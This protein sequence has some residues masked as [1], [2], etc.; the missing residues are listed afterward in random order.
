MKN[1]QQIVEGISIAGQPTADELKNLAG[2]GYR[3]VINLR[4]EG[5]EGAGAD[6]ER[7]VEGAGVNYSSIPIS[8]QTIDDNAVTR[9]IQALDSEDGRP[10]VA[11]CGSGGRAGIMVLLHEA[12]KHAWSVDQALA[13][14]AKLGIAP[15]ENSPYRAFFEDY[16]RRHS[17][18][19]RGE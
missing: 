13:E 19:E 3:T 4:G 6:E 18:A 12:I 14:G 5:E 17:P 16:I 7:L 2:S 15:G 11:H 10:A 1:E 8:P 9:F